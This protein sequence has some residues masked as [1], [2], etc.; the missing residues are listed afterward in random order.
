[1]TLNVTLTNGYVPPI[2]TQFQIISSPGTYGSFSTLNVPAGMAV[3]YSNTSGVYLTV[4][5]STPVQLQSPKISGGNFVFGFGTTNGLGYTVQQNSDLSTTN[6][7]YYTNLIGN[8]SLYQ[9]VAPGTNV[10]QLFFRVRQP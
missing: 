1:L 7:T 3:T 9:V 4:T 10:T 2:G 6:W 5:G 8:G